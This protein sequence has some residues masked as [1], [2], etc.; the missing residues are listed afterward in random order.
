VLAL[1]IA[2]SLLAPPVEL[3]IL[4][5]GNSHTSY[6]GVPAMVEQMLENDGSKRS[7]SSHL[8]GHVFVEDQAESQSTLRELRSGNWDIV[9]MQGAKLSMSHRREYPHDGAVEVAQIAKRAGSRVLLF[10]E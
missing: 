6:N 3:R 2:T 5:L 7:V 1:C 4:Y 8:I 9:V 10:A